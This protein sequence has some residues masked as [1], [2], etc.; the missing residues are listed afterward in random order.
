MNWLF[1]KLHRKQILLSFGLLTVYAAFAIITGKHQ[2][3]NMHQATY[4]GNDTWRN[5]IRL[6]L[7]LPLLLGMFWGAPLLSRE[8]EENTA[9]L[10]WTQGASRRHT[11]LVSI[12][13]MVLLAGLFGLACSGLSGWWVTTDKFLSSRFS[14]IG[15]DTSG[16]MPIVYAIFG[17][18]LGIFCGAYFK[19]A[20][21]ALGVTLIALVLL[22]YGWGTYVRPYYISPH[23]ITANA[24]G[25]FNVPLANSKGGL[26]VDSAK[27]TCVTRSLGGKYCYSPTLHYQPAYLYWDFQRIE[28]G[29]Y[30]SFSLLLVAATYWLVTKRDA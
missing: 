30:L 18:M 1:W 9:K 11:L 22:L 16:L 19:K 20:L 8:Y 2:L 23:A 12:G 10:L 3:H 28:A 14:L 5:I 24:D 7:A 27:P 29:I 17:I 4:L 15:F 25:T 26:I 6:P 13:W 21:L